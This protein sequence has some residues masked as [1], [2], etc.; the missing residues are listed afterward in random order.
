[1]RSATVV[2]EITPNYVTFD[3]CGKRLDYVM[4]GRFIM[5]PG[6]QVSL[7]GLRRRCVLHGI[8]QRV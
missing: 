7:L 6:M 2:P 3:V 4:L 5:L 1:M 8:S